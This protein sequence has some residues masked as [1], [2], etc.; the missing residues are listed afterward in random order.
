MEYSSRGLE[1]LSQERSRTRDY[2]SEPEMTNRWQVKQRSAIFGTEDGTMSL[3]QRGCE[4]AIIS[5]Y[6]MAY[7]AVDEEYSFVL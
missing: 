6:D 5:G 4:C 7:D 1:V 3:A 2:A